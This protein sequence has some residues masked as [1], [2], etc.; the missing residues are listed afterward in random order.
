MPTPQMY[1]Q[2][3]G[4]QAFVT[5]PPE[6]RTPDVSYLY[7][8]DRMPE[9]DPNKTTVYGQSRSRSLAYGSAVVEMG[10]GLSWSSLEQQ[11]QEGKRTEKVNLEM[12]AVVELGRFPD[13]PYK[14]ELSVDGLIR[15]PDSVQSHNEAKAG[16]Q[17]EL[18]RRLA[19]SP[20]KQVV[21]YVHGF[22]ETFASASYTI[23]ELCHFLGRQDVCAMFTWPASSSGAV[24]R[25]YTSTTESAEYSVGHLHKM[26]RMIA[27]TP[28]V[29]GIHLLAHSRGTALLLSAFREL[30]SESIVYGVAPQDYLKLNNLILFAPDIDA[31][32]ALQ[33]MEIFASDPDMLT[34]W[35]SDKLP[36][37]LSGRLTLYTSPKDRAL[38]AS[39]MLFRSSRRIGLLNPD[40]LS[41]E[42]MELLS[43]WGKVDIMVDEGKRSDLLG[44]L[45]FTSNPVVSSDFIQLIRHGTK[46]GE[47]GRPAKSLAPWIWALDADPVMS[48]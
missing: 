22:N 45:Y 42:E 9:T 46:P 20:S 18:Q 25:S 6:R 44:H 33:K 43:D 40:E 23:G 24:V 35:P 17:A 48:E 4:E 19:L 3:G 38:L 2:P 36:D 8:T 1:Q 21:L 47:P 7:I 37:T 31:D 41:A 30:V 27:Q 26:I 39:R 15:S 12:G 32:V 11:S 5:T 16:L 13:E 29:E 34:R 14:M 28:G 10:E